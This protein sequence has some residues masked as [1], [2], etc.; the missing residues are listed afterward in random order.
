MS[1]RAVFFDLDG[2]LL[3]TLKDIAGC[4]NRVLLSRGM[5]PHN[6]EAYKYLVGE[7]REMLVQRMLP[8]GRRD[9][10]TIEQ[11]VTAVDDEYLLHWADTT[12]PYPGI[13]ELLRSLTE[14]GIILAVISNKADEFTRMAVDRMLSEFHFAAVLGARPAVPKK[15]DPTVALEMAVSLGIEPRDVLFLG[16]TDI[17]MKTARAAGMRPLGALWGFRGAVELLAGGA[18][19]LLRTPAELLELL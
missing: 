10:E 8:A 12:A 9:P 15:P 1:C 18:E 6:L 19:A 3:D 7:G 11:A 5:P 4:C 13:P 14:R 16:D 17:D 2:T